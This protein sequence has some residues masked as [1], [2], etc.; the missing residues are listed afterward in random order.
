MEIR[1]EKKDLTGSVTFNSRE[2]GQGDLFVAVRGS[3]TDGHQYISSATAQGAMLVVCEEFP[4]E[5]TN[6]VCYIRVEDSH[7]ALALIASNYY[8]NPSA[9]LSLVGVT[10][11]NGK[12]TV[13]S[14]L[15]DVAAGLGY[16]AGL[17]STVGVR[18]DGHAH[19]A[20][21]T[22][23]DPLQIQSV[24]RE[25]ADAGC[26]FV[27]MEV[28][29][30]AID[31]KRI[32]G[33][34]FRGGIFTNLSHDHLDYHKTFRNYLET[35]KS[36]FDHL[37]AEAFALTNVDDRNGKVMVQNCRASVY[38]YGLKGMADFRGKVLESHFEGNLLQ[39]NHHELWTRLPGMFNAYN[40]LAVFGA[41]I[42]L[43]LDEQ[44][45]TKQISLSRPVDGRFEIIGKEGGPTAIVD[46][47]HTPDALE[48]VLNTIREIRRK[49]ERIV[50]IVG[51][52]GNRDRT[53]RPEMARIAAR[54]SD[55]VILTSDNPRDEDPL[56]I[57]GDMKKGL[58]SELVKK[59]VVIS[60]RAEAIRAT[61]AFAEKRDIILLAGK[62]HETYQEIK[63]V[64]HHFDDREQLRNCL[65]L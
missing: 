20:T 63:G 8:G 16:G 52:G 57:I 26:E 25:M 42:L 27:F 15:C 14:V 9:E 34:T 30:H 18:Y 19:P 55:R 56:D 4:G 37:P 11:T 28:S 65:N 47:A 13:A 31:Q 51:A 48:N 58:D 17:I 1:G 36:F 24:L 43:G 21:H 53:K 50:T 22:T 41:G 3:R 2:A 44:E 62:G 59:V 54:L 7:R 45:L 38:T 6:D 60:D 32:E 23:P 49:G 35:K 39:V 12:T 64:K 46:Y 61:C 10:G 33:L 40:I 5:T 29:S